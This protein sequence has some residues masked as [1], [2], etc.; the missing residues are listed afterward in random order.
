MSLNYNKPPK[1]SLRSLV[2]RALINRYDF[3]EVNIS[4]K[5]DI[6]GIVDMGY[7]PVAK[8]EYGNISDWSWRRTPSMNI[9]VLRGDIVVFTFHSDN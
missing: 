7:A 4:R 9:Q 3:A 8:I 5:G 2:R 1:S 6:V